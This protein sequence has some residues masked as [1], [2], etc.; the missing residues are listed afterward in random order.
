VSKRRDPLANLHTM[1][2]E[3]DVLFGDM[4]E[5]AGLGGRRGGFRPRVD[6]Y[7]CD[8]PPTAVVK[9]DLAG[10]DM[11]DVS[12][13]MRGRTLVISGQRSS[14]ESEARVYHQIEIEQG[15]FA[16]EVELAVPVDASR[17]SASYE[18]GLLIV[19]LPISQP[20]AST[21]VPISGQR[22][23]GAEGEEH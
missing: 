18:D 7:Y 15:R 22:S 23:A 19:K 10:V 2:R 8:D 1:R 14:R 21:R 12:L 9:A 17:A 5:R 20:N 3:I 11:N 13:E 16:R 6:V 4:W